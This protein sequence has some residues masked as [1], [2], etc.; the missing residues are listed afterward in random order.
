MTPIVASEGKN[1]HENG[2]MKNSTMCCMFRQTWG[3]NKDKCV[4]NINSDV[5]SLD[6]RQ[7]G[8]S[9]YFLIWLQEVLAFDWSIVI[10]QSKVYLL[11]F[12]IA[13]VMFYCF[14]SYFLWGPVICVDWADYSDGIDW[15]LTDKRTKGHNDK[16]PKDEWRVKLIYHELITSFL[17]KS[18]N[19]ERFSVIKPGPSP[20]EQSFYRQNHLRQWEGLNQD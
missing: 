4:S 16:G 13:F 15:R 11:C 5:K 20:T 1:K 19:L 3:N 18:V 8:A 7:T 6:P 12:K 17:C 14:L 2:D 9:S 10:V